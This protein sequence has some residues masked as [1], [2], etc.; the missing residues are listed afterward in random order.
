M[1]YGHKEA[2]TGRH[3]EAAQSN[4][5]FGVDFTTTLNEIQRIESALSAIPADDR[6][7]WLKIGMA[8]KAE[9]GTDGFPFFD[10]WSQQASNY[11][12]RDTRDVW[13]SFKAGTVS[14]G[15]L[16]YLA[17]Q[18][19]WTD[20]SP[21][22]NPSK[23]ELK[24]IRQQRLIEAAKAQAEREAAHQ[25]GKIKAEQQWRIARPVTVDHWYLKAKQVMP[26]G[27]RAQGEVLC[28]PMMDETGALWNIQKIDS[29]RGKRFLSGARVSGLFHVIGV[30]T[31][32]L[33]IC[34]GYAT[35][36]T[37]HEYSGHQTYVAFNAGNLMAVARI[38]RQQNPGKRITLCADDDRHLPNNPGLT[39]AKAAAL[40]I[41]GC[42]AV[43]EFPDGV[44]GTDFN[45]LHVYRRGL[46]AGGRYA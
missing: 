22:K 25:K 45:D 1:K 11:R 20:S 24:A 8:L 43:P 46:I 4:R 12:E 40:A 44:S 38:V 27:I 41:G 19:G 31:D 23:A 16:F 2:A 7:S 17:K 14:I 39:K 6:A 30:P 34:E 13:R 32:T 28:I 42:I 21:V 37:A 9:L 18:H 5:I 3:R 15:S 36:A 10:N 26:H 33:L 29:L 35:G